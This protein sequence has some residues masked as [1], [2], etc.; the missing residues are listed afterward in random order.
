MKKYKYIGALPPSM[1]T[2]I[3]SG[4]QYIVPA[5]IEVESGTT[6]N[7]VEW[8]LPDFLKKY[9]NDTTGSIQYS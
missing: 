8:E 7:Q 2:S 1:F 9:N 5:W 4:K 3:F 6:I